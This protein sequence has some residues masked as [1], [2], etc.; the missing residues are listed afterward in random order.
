MKRPVVATVTL[1]IG[2]LF[3]LFGI[4]SYIFGFQSLLKAKPSSF[5]QIADSW[6]IITIIAYLHEIYKKNN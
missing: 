4:V 5:F 3:M 2:L 1:Y 6:F